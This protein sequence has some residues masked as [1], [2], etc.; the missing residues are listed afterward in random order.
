MHGIRLESDPEGVIVQLPS[1]EGSVP[2]RVVINDAH[3]LFTAHFKKS[4]PD[5]ILTDDGGKKIVIAGYF[6]FEKHPD[7]VSPDGAILQADLVER[8]AGS[9]VPG[10]YAQAG[11]PIGAEVIGRVELVNSGCTV[12]HSNGVTEELKAGDA[13]LKGDVIITGESQTATLSLRDGTV[14]NMGVNARMVLAELAY[15][16]Q[17]TSNSALINLVKGSFVFVAGQIAHTG[18]MNV[19][20]PVATM[21]I[22]G[23][24][25]GTYL[26]ADVNGNV[27]ELTA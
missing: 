13:L 17:S 23:T 18:G 12:Q 7:L 2:S 15:D 3:F 1:F 27:Y 10:Q 5:L 25:V 24:T 14:F 8:L 6:N 22:R 20:T 4:G 11:A 21:G 26:N 9:N 19:N 16:A